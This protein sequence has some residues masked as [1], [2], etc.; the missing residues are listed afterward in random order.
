MLRVK[1]TIRAI[2]FKLKMISQCDQN[3]V[4]SQPALR[5]MQN[6]GGIAFVRVLLTDVKSF[7]FFWTLR[8]VVH[9]ACA[10]P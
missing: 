3:L 9:P 8:Q 7:T 2:G 6:A 10:N 1:C 4:C 5:Q